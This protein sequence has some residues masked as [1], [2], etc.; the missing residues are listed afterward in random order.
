MKQILL[1]GENTL[2]AFEN[3]A[4]IVCAFQRVFAFENSVHYIMMHFFLPTK[5]SF[6]PKKKAPPIFAQTP[7]IFAH[8]FSPRAFFTPKRLQLF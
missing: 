2:F 5:M 1:P 3:S 6:L 7:P 8:E 4:Q